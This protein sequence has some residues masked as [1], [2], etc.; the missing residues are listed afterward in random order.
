MLV[1]DDVCHTVFCMC[2]PESL[3]HIISLLNLHSVL[4]NENFFHPF[5]E[6]LMLCTTLSRIT[7]K[8][9]YISVF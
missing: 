2:F 9:H 6:V 8:T 1:N 4:D 7:N 3:T 5:Q